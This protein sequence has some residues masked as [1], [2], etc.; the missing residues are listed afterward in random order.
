MADEKPAHKSWFV[1]WFKTGLTTVF[2]LVSGACLMYFSGVINYVIKPSKPLANFE[3]Q[4]N[5]LKVVFH[6]RCTGGNDGWWDFGDGAALQP[7][8]AD[9]ETVEHVYTRPSSYSVKLSLRNLFGDEN[10]RSVNVTVGDAAVAAPPSIDTFEVVPIGAGPCNYAPATFKVVSKVKNADMCVWVPGYEYPV[11]VITDVAGAQ[12]RYVT[13][14][15]PGYHMLKLAAYANKQVIEKSQVVKVEPQRPDAVMAVLNISHQAV[16][17]AKE[18][19]THHIAVDV[20]PGA[21]GSVCQFAKE[22]WAKPGYQ[23]LAAGFAKPTLPANVR[24]AKLEVAPDKLKV[25]LT[26]ELVRVANTP[27]KWVTEVVLTEEQRSP[28]TTIPL[29]TVAYPLTIPGTTTL[30]M[31]CLQGGW[32][33]T[34]RSLTLALHDAKEQ[35]LWQCAAMPRTDEL[36]L[37]G[38][39]Y[40]LTATEAGGQLRIEVIDVGKAAPLLGN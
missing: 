25:R 7:F 27:L 33:S 26:G 22:R 6:N 16:H 37:G 38:R 40:R 29:G 23:I 9:Q 19:R 5:G 18:S 36:T 32:V 11:E 3:T 15:Q 2:G 35:T 1:H 24:G 12:E 8:V 13:L 20:P 39:R 14:K 28:M 30:P 34:Q 17:V 21:A 31:P 4:V 10:E